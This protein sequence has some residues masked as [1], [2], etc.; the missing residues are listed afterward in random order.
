MNEAAAAALCVCFG[1]FSHGGLL[2]LFVNYSSTTSTTT[3]TYVC[4]RHAVVGVPS[5]YF[6]FTLHGFFLY[7]ARQ[8]R[9]LELS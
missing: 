9:F 3:T 1:Y 7:S 5:I 4:R 6:P 2:Q 8:R